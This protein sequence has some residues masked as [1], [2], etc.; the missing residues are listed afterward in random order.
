VT[1]LLNLFVPFYV[2]L[3][4]VSMPLPVSTD[5]LLE[6]VHKGFFDGAAEVINV[7]HYEADGGGSA[8]L[9]E[10][11]FG[12]LRSLDSTL[13]AIITPHVIYTELECKILNTDGELVN[14]ETLIIPAVRGTGR[15][16][17]ASE[18]PFVNWTFKLIRPDA[19]FR[20]GWKRY[21]GVPKDEV[22][23][24]IAGSGIASLL[25]AHAVTL[26]AVIHSYSYDYGDDTFTE[27]GATMNPVILQRVVNGTRVSPVNVA[28]LA[29][30]AYSKIGSQNSRKY[31]RGS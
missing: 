31:G 13:N 29:G 12:L 5:A 8:T 30:A 27:T 11:G 21:A 22:N 20:H 2:D 7:Y 26:N 6:F 4:S 23:Q 24:G 15:K 9:D 25:N 3:R 18:A 10:Y 14:G 19:S 1:A 16:G 28:E 17:T